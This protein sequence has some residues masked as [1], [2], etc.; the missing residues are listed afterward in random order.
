MQA[1]VAV[2]FAIVVSTQML[3]RMAQSD[4]HRARVNLG[5][6]Q[7]QQVDRLTQAAN[8]YAAANLTTLAQGTGTIL[9]A[10]GVTAT[11]SNIYSPTVTELTSMGYLKANFSTTN[12]FGGGY[13][14]SLSL[15]PN[16]CSYPNCSVGGTVSLTNAI[17]SNGVPDITVLAAA[18]QAVGS[19]MGYSKQT[20]TGTIYGHSG[21]WSATNPAGNVAGI[22]AEQVNATSLDGIYYRLD[23]AVGLKNTLNAGGQLLGNIKTAAPG[24][25]C[26]S[27]TLAMSDGTNS[28]SAGLVM[29]CQSGVWA[30][31]GATYWQDPVASYAA[32]P[33]CNAAA[34]WQTRI[35]QTPT[36]GTGPRAYTCNGSTWM[37]VGLN[38]SGS[39]TIAGTATINALAGNLQVTATA[40]EGAACTG[41]GRIAQSTTT[42]GLILS[43]QSGTWRNTSSF[44]WGGTCTASFFATASPGNTC[45]IE[46][47]RSVVYAGTTSGIRLI[48]FPADQGLIGWYEG[49]GLCAGSG[50]GF[51]MPTLADLGVMY[52]NRAVIGG[53]QASGYWAT[54]CD[55]YKSDQSCGGA[56]ELW[57]NSG[58]NG[59]GAK[60]STT[61]YVRCV[62]YF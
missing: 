46:D 21:G 57:F 34:T 28:V 17:T 16:G 20:N 15:L 31:Q 23:G 62:R 32:L 10:S 59:W 19:A 3:G 47:G 7:G 56:R 9:N 58:A 5:T 24:A 29:S 45:T 43:C 60:D 33:T 53:F 4:L 35:V 52:T 8:S 51:V 18:T 26:T 2:A 30:T 6:A 36:T 37:P 22:L 44:T 11:V 42:S 25:A 39:I 13:K 41:D 50:I 1:L 38:D 40:A 27:N 49:H 12:Y 54:D 48:V 14:V 55:S 61:H